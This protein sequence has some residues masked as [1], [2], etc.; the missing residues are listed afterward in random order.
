[1]KKNIVKSF[2]DSGFSLIELLIVIV[3]IG[4]LTSMTMPFLRSPDYR[5]KKIAREL[6][7]DMQNT[8]IKAV[9]DNMDRAIVFDAVNNRYF[10]C[11]DSGADNVWSTTGDNTILKTVSFSD[12][13]TGVVYGSGPA[14]TNA[15]VGG[16]AFPVDFISYTSNVLTFNS[17]GTCSAGW[18]YISNTD[19][20]YAIGTLSTGLVR[21][22]HWRSGSGDWR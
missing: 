19:A 5:V 7:G 18:V 12:V 17:R 21:L 14:T 8:R 2:K 20:A 9:K 22:R 6:M 16:G 11:S 13:V 15:N 1:M 3:I 4:I 10:I